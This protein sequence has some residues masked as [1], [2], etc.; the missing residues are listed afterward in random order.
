MKVTIWC[1]H[2]NILQQKIKLC[3][4]RGNKLSVLTL[5]GSSLK[6]DLHLQA[7]QKKVK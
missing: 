3:I 1:P 4:Y 2:T 7:E 5:I 6:N